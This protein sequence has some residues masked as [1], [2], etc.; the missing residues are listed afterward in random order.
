MRREVP[1]GLSIFKK[2]NNNIISLRPPK[3]IRYELGVASRERGFNFGEP[4]PM[5]TVLTYGKL[6]LIF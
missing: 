6:L 3:L 4:G 2:I 5:N 1:L